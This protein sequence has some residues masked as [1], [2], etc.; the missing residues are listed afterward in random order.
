MNSL[1]EPSIIEALYAPQSQAWKLTSSFAASAPFA[2]ECA[3]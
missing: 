1:L 3:A 2:P